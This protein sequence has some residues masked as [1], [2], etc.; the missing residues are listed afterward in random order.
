MQ[1][2]LSL[3]PRR[4]VVA[5]AKNLNCY[6]ETTK[7]MPTKGT[8]ICFV[9]FCRNQ[10][11]SL[12]KGCARFNA[13]EFN[14]CKLNLMARLLLSSPKLLKSLMGLY[15]R[16]TSQKLDQKDFYLLIKFLLGLFDLWPRGKHGKAP[17]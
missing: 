1:K 7:E 5:S 17:Q 6:W 13:F 16:E 15:D 12:S 3:C 10:M 4:C 11:C 8:E 2:V 14:I 9:Q